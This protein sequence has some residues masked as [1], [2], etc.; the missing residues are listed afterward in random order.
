MSTLRDPVTKQKVKCNC[1]PPCDDV[2]YIIE[3]D[4][5]MPW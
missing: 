1:L 3:N 2:N 5:T 4:H